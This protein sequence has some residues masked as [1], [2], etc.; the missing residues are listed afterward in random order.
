MATESQQESSGD[1]N[2]LMGSDFTAIRESRGLTLNDVF[3][4]TKISAVNLELIE[5]EDF[6]L[7]PPPVYA[8][9][10]IKA[11][12][13]LLGVEEEKALN[14]YE[15]Y[16]ASVS[17]ADA[18][19][20]E[21]GR[22]EAMSPSKKIIIAASL[23]IAVCF[24]LFI[25]YLHSDN[26]TVDVQTGGDLSARSQIKSAEK[27]INGT[28]PEKPEAV[29]Q[30]KQ[31]AAKEE[32]LT[33]AK[34]AEKASP[35]QL[36]TAANDPTQRATAA[37]KPEQIPAAGLNR[38]V[39]TAREI[40]WVRISEDGKKAYQFLMRPGEKLERSASKFNMD[41]GN[42]GGISLEFQGKK[43]ESL[44]KSGEVVHVNLP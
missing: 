37:A 23:L 42:A 4:V 13:S 35:A 22:E 1:K 38:L 34:V 32:K 20:P 11:Y 15:K 39:V 6:Q 18:E 5:K 10:Y 8:R 19:K 9:A 21:P 7:L 25:I 12:A 29:V 28:L 30:E 17:D 3:R 26:Q 40:T 16:L 2:E 27:A 14:P 43:M 44:G 41:V 33:Q 31:Q 24:L 36:S